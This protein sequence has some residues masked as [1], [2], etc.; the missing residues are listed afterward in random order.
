MKLSNI[1][2]DV[3][4]DVIADIL[5][6]IGNIA[7]D[8]KSKKLFTKVKPKDGEEQYT[9]VL[10]HVTKNVPSLLKNHKED[11]IKILS[12]IAMMSVEEYKSQMTLTSLI[13]DCIELLTDTVAMNLFTTAQSEQQDE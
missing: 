13:D 6:P 12:S 8:P 11:L 10:K 4:L 2:G 9:A 7:S 5:E 3:A 1:K